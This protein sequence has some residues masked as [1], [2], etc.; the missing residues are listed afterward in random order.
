MTALLP[1]AAIP[2]FAERPRAV[3][4][5][6]DVAIGCLLPEI[7]RVV[8]LPHVDLVSFDQRVLGRVSI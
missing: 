3:N 6:R 8:A 5:E 2:A 1:Y 7:L 4:D